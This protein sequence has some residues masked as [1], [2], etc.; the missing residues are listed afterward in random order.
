MFS[1]GSLA[2]QEVSS[3]TSWTPLTFNPPSGGLCHTLSAGEPPSSW[4]ISKW[5]SPIQHSQPH[6]TLTG[7]M[8]K[9]KADVCAPEFIHRNREFQQ[10]GPPGT[11]VVIKHKGV[12]LTS[13]WLSRAKRD[14]ILTKET[15]RLKTASLEDYFNKAA[16]Q[17]LCLTCL[18]PK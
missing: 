9:L 18:L 17:S 14:K 16:E 13:W 6:R 12:V 3:L 5:T 8:S 2:L 10:L 4:Q 7:T 15:C 11:V 1:E